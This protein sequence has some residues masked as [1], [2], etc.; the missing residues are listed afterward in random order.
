MD[1][2][3]YYYLIPTKD[4][5]TLQVEFDESLYNEG[6]NPNDVCRPRKYKFRNLDT[7]G[8]LP[9]GCKLPTDERELSGIMSPSSVVTV[10]PYAK[11]M[12]GIS[13]DAEYFAYLHPPTFLAD[14]LAKIG[15]L[16]GLL[17]TED[18]RVQIANFA[19]FGAFVYFDDE[20]ESVGISILST[21]KTNFKLPLRGPFPTS[22]IAMKEVQDRG[23]FHTESLESHHEMGVH[24]IV[25][26]SSNLSNSYD[27]PFH[28]L[29][30]SCLIS[31]SAS[32]S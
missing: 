12:I 1:S 21:L 5:K 23:R 24:E 17:D 19:M 9:E 13:Q 31:N 18:V 22:E 2:S 3:I 10:P 32:I 29:I 26:I 6:I 4:F 28:C 27:T 15:F 20:M 16:K 8:F 14:Y 25:S 30:P 11:K 7:C